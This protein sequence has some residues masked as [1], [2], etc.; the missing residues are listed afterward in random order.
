MG[1]FVS[2]TDKAGL[3]VSGGDSGVILPLDKVARVTLFEQHQG[4][5]GV[6]SAGTGD[7]QKHDE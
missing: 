7:G 6:F 2:R 4:A 1:C 3:P 5:T